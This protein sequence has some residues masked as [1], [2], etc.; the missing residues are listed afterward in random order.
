M[1]R[2]R[3]CTEQLAITLIRP[4]FEV[5]GTA[6]GLP[7]SRG[8]QAEFGSAPGRRTSALGF[9]PVY[10]QKWA[11]PVPRPA[12]GINVHREGLEPSTN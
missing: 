2:V 8:Q 11:W 10:P 1:A 12:K 9:P 3:P 5:G 4:G 6:L 7:P